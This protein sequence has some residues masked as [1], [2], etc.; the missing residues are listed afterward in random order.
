M[1]AKRVILVEGPS[2]EVV[3]QRAYRDAHGGRLPIEDGVDVIS[4]RG[5]QAK[6][7]LDLV[8]TSVGV[9]DLGYG[10]AADRRRSI[11][12]PRSAGGKVA[13]IPGA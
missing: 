3:I 2:D 9:V 12:L 6:R 5:L 8:R 11:D 10:I 13:L 4:V 7:F 1:L